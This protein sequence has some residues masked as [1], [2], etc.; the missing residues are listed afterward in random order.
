MADAPNPLFDPW[1]EEDRDFSSAREGRLVSSAAIGAV[2]RDVSASM[3]SRRR[4][5][6]PPSPLRFNPVFRWGMAVLTAVGQLAAAWAV[7]TWPGGFDS[8][9]S[10]MSDFATT[11]GGLRGAIVFAFY[12]PLSLLTLIV[13]LTNRWLVSAGRWGWWWYFYLPLSTT[14]YWL[15][16][17]RPLWWRDDHVDHRA[18]RSGLYA[19]RTMLL[20]SLFVFALPLAVV[21]AVGVVSGG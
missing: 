21:R 13:M 9:G 10:P 14:A 12:L 1:R 15:V 18:R 6:P 16:E 11:H 7:L 4:D 8:I 5:R 2:T 20:A 19:F 3:R 17:P